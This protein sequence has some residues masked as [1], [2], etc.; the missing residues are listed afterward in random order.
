[1]RILLT[2]D[3]GIDA[4]GINALA[5][6]LKDNGH[7]IIIVAPD[8]EQSAASHSIT[9]HQPLRIIERGNHRFA[10]TGSPA[11][12]V[13]LA[14]KVIVKTPLDLV[15][16]GINGGQNMGEDVLYS[17]TVA[18]ALEAMFMG[19]KAIAVSLASYKEQKFQT[20]AFYIHKLLKAGIHDLIDK[21]EI[22]NINVPNVEKGE[23][24][25]VRITHTG[26]R[27][28]KDFVAEQHDP[29]GRKIYW[30]GGDNAL[31]ENDDGSDSIAVL[32]NYVSI[33]PLSPKFTKYDSFAKLKN[34]QNKQ[35]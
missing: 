32:N 19:F 30:I 22:L 9:L 11:D 17:G 26:H 10:I 14:A 25:G 5:D 35:G 12:C 20:A 18:A 29:R 4:P 16:S 1:M 24:E 3:D 6:E 23:I 34:W 2:N 15:I 28:Y 33:T 8:K 27:R 31:W 21:D 7:Q 13:I